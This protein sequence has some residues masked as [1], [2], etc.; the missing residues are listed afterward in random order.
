MHWRQFLL[1][2]TLLI[3]GMLSLGGC[4]GKSPPSTQ[5]DG[6]GCY[7]AVVRAERLALVRQWAPKAER[8]DRLITASCDDSRDEE[9]LNLTRR[10]LM[11]S[12]GP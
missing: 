9:L 12:P 6:R 7:V 3:G 8:G 5:A 11:R 2:S 10:L 4:A 1:I